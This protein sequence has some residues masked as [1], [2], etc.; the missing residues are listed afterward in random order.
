[1]V[2]GRRGMPAEP[3]E[4]AA[5]Q[6][7]FER[8]PKKTLGLV[9]LVAL[10]ALVF[11]AEKGLSFRVKAPE[12]G[13]QRYVRL[14]ELPPRHYEVTIPPQGVLEPGGGT[15]PPQSR[16]RADSQGFIIPSRVH[17]EPDVVIAFLGGS[18]TECR[19]QAEERR[20]AYA[21]GRLLE[22][23]THRKI[24][25]YNAG[26]SGNNTLHNL[27]ILLH[28]V[29]PLKPDVVVLMENVNDLSTLLYEGSYWNK[30]ASRRP[31][32]EVTPSLSREFREFLAALRQ[33]LIPNLYAALKGLGRQDPAPPD[34]F[35]H[36]RGRRLSI[37]EAF[38]LREFTA[39]LTN[40]IDICRARGITPVLMT[41][42]NRFTETLD[43]KI[44]QQ[45]R[46]IEAQGI[47]YRD[48]QAVY[49]R[50]NQAIRE[51]G[52]KQGVLVIDLA[53][54]VPQDKMHLFDAVHFTDQGAD[55][56]ARTVAEALAPLVAKARPR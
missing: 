29:L 19:Y 17:A 25:A 35:A 18:T 53:R 45:V 56:V 33:A 52:A 47:A 22:Q 7:W 20:F 27:T 16:L 55:L 50:F 31:V 5:K 51:V 11:A 6:N 21:A 12:A 15:L 2:K 37:D 1:M 9:L 34:E 14:R 10:A 54:L 49:D 41:Q 32:V 43:A 4:T 3:Q 13:V 39:N 24:N 36:V 46:P 26:R 30:N 44:A 48:Y 8:H 38:L 23:Q 42:A 40:F 28:K